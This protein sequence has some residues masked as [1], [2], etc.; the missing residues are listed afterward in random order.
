[1]KFNCNCVFSGAYRSGNLG[2][3]GFSLLKMD[4]HQ[5]EIKTLQ[6]EI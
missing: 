4:E 5:L 6:R 1:M 2:L 3:K